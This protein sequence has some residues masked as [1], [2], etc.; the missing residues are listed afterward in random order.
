MSRKT[1]IILILSGYVITYILALIFHWGYFLSLCI[2][3]FLSAT[4]AL[5]MV[6][7]SQ[8][9]YNFI[10]N[11]QYD[12]TGH[13]LV[14]SMVGDQG[15]KILLSVK[16]LHC[17]IDVQRLIQFLAEHNYHQTEQFLA[18]N[19]SIIVEYS[20][21]KAI[22]TYFKTKKFIYGLVDIGLVHLMQNNVNH[23]FMSK[24]VKVKKS[25]FFWR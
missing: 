20:F 9:Q 25:L 16:R 5:A 14:F 7:I 1:G 13:I 3:G 18:I 23:G 11:L 17:L 4:I 21:K 24:P 12:N 6:N 2:Y 8:K 10:L 15:Q 22:K 19:E